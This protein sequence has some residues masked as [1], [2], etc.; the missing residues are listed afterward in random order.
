MLL[1]FFIFLYFPF[2]YQWIQIT[3]VIRKT[4]ISIELSTFLT[5]FKIKFKFLPSALE[6]VCD[7]A[8]QGSHVLISRNLQ[9]HTAYNHRT[10]QITYYFSRCPFLTPSLPHLPHL[11]SSD[12]P[13]RLPLSGPPCKKPPLSPPP[14]LSALL[15]SN[16][17]GHLGHDAV[18]LY[19]LFCLP[20]LL[21]WDSRRQRQCLYFCFHSI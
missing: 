7:L 17:Q 5:V 21:D 13:S 2:C 12:S 1:L 9:T 10:L 16:I 18:H 6:A 11:G 8:L 15:S 14:L 20:A 3:F 4:Y 19:V